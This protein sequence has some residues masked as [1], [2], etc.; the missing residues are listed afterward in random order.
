[1]F[2]AKLNRFDVYLDL[3][4]LGLS[5]KVLHEKFGRFAQLVVFALVDEG[6][7]LGE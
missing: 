2:L 6:L 3:G 5:S 7:L 4:F 1:V